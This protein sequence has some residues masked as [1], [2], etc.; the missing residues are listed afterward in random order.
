LT[1]TV[2]FTLIT[3]LFLLLVSQLTVWRHELPSPPKVTPWKEVS[4]TRIK[5]AGQQNGR[6]DNVDDANP[7]AIKVLKPEH[8]SN[9]DVAGLK[10]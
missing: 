6:K 1:K 7:S 5:P 4:F 9:N 8:P 2:L 3:L 10:Q